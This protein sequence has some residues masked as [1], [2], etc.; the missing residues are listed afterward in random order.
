MKFFILFSYKVSSHVSFLD[1]SLPTGQY[2][3]QG[4]GPL[5]RYPIYSRRPWPW[6]WLWP[7]LRSGHARAKEVIEQAVLRDRTAFSISKV[8]LPVVQDR[9]AAEARVEYWGMIQNS[10]LQICGFG[11]RGI[12]SFF[13]PARQSE[14]CRQENLL[15]ARRRTLDR[16]C[17]NYLERA[18]KTLE[19]L[20]EELA[21]TCYVRTIGRERN[22]GVLISEPPDL[23]KKCMLQSTFV[24]VKEH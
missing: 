18:G 20:I 12:I 4:K 5:P 21:P 6:P 24:C 19:A 8:R 3:S 13:P 7:L 1:S 16:S 2:L 9:L 22:L 15:L 17:C 14:S 10:C 11:R 23:L